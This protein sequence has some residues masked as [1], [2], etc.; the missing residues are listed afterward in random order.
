MISVDKVGVLKKT[1]LFGPF[2][3]SGSKVFP[4]VCGERKLNKGETLFF[5]GEEAKGLYVI[6]RGSLRS[7]RE[8]SEGRE[9][10]ILIER[11]GTTVGEVPM[12]DDKPYHST[13]VANEDSEVLF[14]S[15]N[16]V[17]RLCSNHPAVALAALRLLA[18]RFRETAALAES[19]SLKTVDQRLAAFLL[20]EFKEKRLRKLKLPTISA[21][22]AHLGSVREVVSRAF[23]KLENEKLVLIDDHR[24]LSLL[25]EERLADF[26]CA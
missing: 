15:K 5:A 2:L 19:L 4:D 7:Y 13:V 3:Q 22:A 20:R 23:T 10:V 11:A 6:A 24:T 18:E 26:A 1:E 12:F 8:N 21:I 25:D 14:I 17:R 16:E 9:Q